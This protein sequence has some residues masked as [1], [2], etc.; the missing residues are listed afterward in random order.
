MLVIFCK[1]YYYYTVNLFV[2]FLVILIRLNVSIPIANTT[3]YLTQNMNNLDV[4]F[5]HFA[6][7]SDKHHIQGKGVLI[8]KSSGFE[9]W[10]AFGLVYLFIHSVTYITLDTSITDYNLQHNL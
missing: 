3:G 10:H 9:L 4:S 7:F 1:H 5:G 6:G 2:W 8:T